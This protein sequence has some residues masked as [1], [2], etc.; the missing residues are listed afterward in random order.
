LYHYIYSHNHV[1]EA[2]MIPYVHIFA[3]K[4]RKAR[5]RQ[6][7]KIAIRH[8]CLVEWSETAYCTP[9]TSSETAYFT[10]GTGT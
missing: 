4:M 10:P 8:T 3:G 2:K 1:K 9:G 5:I 7:V 6:K